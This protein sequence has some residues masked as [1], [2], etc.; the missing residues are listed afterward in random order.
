MYMHNLRGLSRLGA[1]YAPGDLVL[2]AGA[3]P[4]QWA[5][6]LEQ[7]APGI[8]SLVDDQASSGQSWIDSLAAAVSTVAATYQQKQLL[9]VQIQ[10]ARQGLPPLDVSAYAPGVRVGLSEDTQRMLVI[11]GVAALVL[12]AWSVSRR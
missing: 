12:L 6:S 1:T 8:T 3:I 4:G 9:D 7:L 5:A 2:D 11:G 10:R